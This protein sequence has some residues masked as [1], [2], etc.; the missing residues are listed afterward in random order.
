MRLVLIREDAE[1]DGVDFYGREVDE[2]PV[3]MT[4]V[5]LDWLARW[6]W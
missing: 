6:L 3:E 2:A 5:Y 4:A 1:F